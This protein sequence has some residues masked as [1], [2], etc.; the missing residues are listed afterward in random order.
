MS[1]VILVDCDNVLLNLNAAWIKELNRIY[2]TDY[3]P[4]DVNSWDFSNLF[5]G[6]TMKDLLETLYSDDN[7]WRTIE[8]IVDANYYLRWLQ[9][10]GNIIYIVTATDYRNIQMK[11]DFGIHKYFPFIKDEQII[12]CHNKQLLQADY[13][14]DDNVDNLIGGGYKKLL[15][16]QPHNSGLDLSDPKYKDIIR[17]NNWEDCYNNIIK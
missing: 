8:P 12:T 15:F 1:K 17:C 13:L 5:P 14:I 7:V 6:Y 3:L 16:T 11:I 4:T 10:L 2:H 9:D